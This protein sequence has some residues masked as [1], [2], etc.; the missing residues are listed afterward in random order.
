MSITALAI[1]RIV[2]GYGTMMR[3]FRRQKV[4]AELSSLDDRL[5]RDIGLTRFDVEAMR[6]MW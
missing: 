6:R 2:L 1:D 3:P 5:L 4:A